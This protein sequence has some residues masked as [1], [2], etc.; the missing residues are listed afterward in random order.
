MLSAKINN[1]L[2][3]KFSEKIRIFL[4]ENFPTIR[5]IK[6]PLHAINIGKLARIHAALFFAQISWSTSADA[7]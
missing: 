1:V 2:W 7:I 6:L 3:T 4:V 5:S